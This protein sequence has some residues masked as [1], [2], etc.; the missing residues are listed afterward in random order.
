MPHR[1]WQAGG[2]RWQY[3]RRSGTCVHPRRRDH[4]TPPWPEYAPAH[5][6]PHGHG[7]STKT[8]ATET[9]SKGRG[10]FRTHDQHNAGDGPVNGQ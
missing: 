6:H 4:C 9:S 7:S 8:T 3:P 1:F 2:P 5:H 10:K